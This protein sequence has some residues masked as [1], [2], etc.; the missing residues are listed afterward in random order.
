[1]VKGKGPKN[2]KADVI[3]KASRF[4]LTSPDPFERES[5]RR[6]PR[7]V[8]YLELYAK[9]GQLVTTAFKVGLN[10]STI[11]RWLKEW[12]EFAAKFREADELYV[13]SLEQA[14]DARA[15]TKSDLLAM[16]R[17]KA[18]RPR[19]YREQTEIMHKGAV[20][21]DVIIEQYKGKPVDERGGGTD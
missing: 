21:F 2:V 1:M 19:I 10:K 9:T 20:V 16:F 11:D 7:A 4:E 12:P 3:K 5:P 17:L 8:R 13:E 6:R 15:R 14:V 18:K